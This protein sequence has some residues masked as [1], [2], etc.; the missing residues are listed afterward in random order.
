MYA[1]YIALLISFGRYWPIFLPS[2]HGRL[3][4]KR[5][6]QI[7]E[8]LLLSKKSRI[9]ALWQVLR[10]SDAQSVSYYVVYTILS[11]Q[12]AP[13]SYIPCQKII[14]H[15]SH[16]HLLAH[17]ASVNRTVVNRQNSFTESA[18]YRERGTAIIKTLS[19]FIC[20]KITSDS[21]SNL[22]EHID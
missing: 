1:A 18:I 17:A 4:S 14:L 11:I 13:H 8:F 21:S 22:N 9:S 16:C 5:H 7:G 3:A 15:Y 2:R 20:I 6:Y 12:L 19:K 10:L